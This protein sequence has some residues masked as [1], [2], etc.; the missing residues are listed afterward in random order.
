MNNR[1]TN[2][3]NVDTKRK[4]NDTVFP[5]WIDENTV[6]KAR[7]SLCSKQNADLLWRKIFSNF[8]F[9]FFLEIDKHQLKMTTVADPSLEQDRLGNLCRKMRVEQSAVCDLSK[10]TDKR[11]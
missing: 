1:A 2:W 3:W 9:Y 6:V 11:K 7:W 8:L 10:K 4:E 5:L